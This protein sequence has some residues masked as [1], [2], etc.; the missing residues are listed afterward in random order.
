M[1]KS[2]PRAFH[3]HRKNRP[4]DACIERTVPLMHWI[5]KALHER[6]SLL[7]NIDNR[8]VDSKIYTNFEME[9]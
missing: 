4:P 5:K 7:R 6:H 2:Q 9:Y 3:A 1:H 8:A